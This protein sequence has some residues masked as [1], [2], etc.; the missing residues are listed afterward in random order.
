M[1]DTDTMIGII[2]EHG[3]EIRVRFGVARLGVFGSRVRG[4]TCVPQRTPSNLGAVHDRMNGGERSLSPRPMRLEIQRTLVRLPGE[5]E[6]P[7]DW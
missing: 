4:D 6:K 1:I 7:W 2:R 3:E 5:A